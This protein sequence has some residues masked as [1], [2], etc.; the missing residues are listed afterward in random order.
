MY[1]RIGK[2]NAVYRD[3]KWRIVRNYPDFVKAINKY[4]GAITHVSFDHDL[5]DGHYHQKMQEGNINY[6]S[7]D[8]SKDDFKKT[9]YHAA[10]QL[11]KVYEEHKL[12]LPVILVHSMN[13]VGRYNIESVF[14]PKAKN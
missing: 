11:K 12:E 5:V 1:D 10:M 8:F 4:K 3:N 9:G 7:E 6:D 13:L 14:E 2:L